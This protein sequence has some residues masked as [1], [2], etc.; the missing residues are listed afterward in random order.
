VQNLVTKKV[1]NSLF[2]VT[3]TNT[4]IPYEVTQNTVFITKFMA[5]MV[6]HLPSKHEALSYTTK[7]YYKVYFH[8]ILFK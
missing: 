5:Q 6:K 3:I 4:V 1:N 2:P 7:I 8:N